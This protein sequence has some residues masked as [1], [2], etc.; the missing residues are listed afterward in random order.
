MKI[1]QLKPCNY[2]S[3]NRLRNLIHPLKDG[4]VM[5]KVGDSYFAEDVKE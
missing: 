5:D 4:G 1:H 2:L 3:R